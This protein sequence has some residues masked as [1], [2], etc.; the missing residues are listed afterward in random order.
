MNAIN[1]I[2]EIASIIASCVF[3]RQY[4][5]RFHG[6]PKSM[7]HS[8]WV[9]QTL[10]SVV[11]ISGGR[12]AAMF[13]AHRDVFDAAFSQGNIMNVSTHT[14]KWLV[15]CF[16]I[17]A[18]IL[19]F[20]VSSMCR[21]NPR[22]RAVYCWVVVPCCILYPVV[23]VSALGLVTHR[24]ISITTAL[25]ALIVLVPTACLSMFVFRSDSFDATLKL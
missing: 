21:G 7:Y 10:F 24:D 11:G 12:F 13:L 2:W 8:I 4:A 18:L 15:C 14:M 17:L 16:S 22:A 20:A 5:H 9:F 1:P 6:L 23:M 3:K 25:C 19:Y